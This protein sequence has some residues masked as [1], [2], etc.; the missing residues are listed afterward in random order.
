MAAITEELALR[1]LLELSTDIRAAFLLDERGK[2]T[3]SAPEPPPERVAGA[4]AKLV[5]E[6]R[7]LANGGQPAV[8]IDVKLDG[9]AAFMVWEGGPALICVTG[10][11]ALPGLI[12][13]DMRIALS[14][15]RRGEETNK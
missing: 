11:F 1:Y 8:E 6:A 5:Q 3:A 2:L 14:D 7:A 13:H 15:L 10:P 12:L 4:G 9:G